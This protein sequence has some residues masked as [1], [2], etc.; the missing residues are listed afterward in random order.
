M[1]IVKIETLRDNLL[2][3]FISILNWRD[4]DVPEEP[5]VSVLD[6]YTKDKMRERDLGR[7]QEAEMFHYR[8]RGLDHRTS[9][10][11]EHCRPFKRVA[12]DIVVVLGY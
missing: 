2:E 9:Y 8:L 11:V 4:L 7:W 12:G 10:G 1:K 5:V 3:K 6:D